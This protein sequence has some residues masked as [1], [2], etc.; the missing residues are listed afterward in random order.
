MS[1]NFCLEN[2]GLKLFHGRK[3]IRD[4]LGSLHM[5]SSLLPVL[6]DLSI[7]GL[8]EGDGGARQGLQL[9]SLEQKYNNLLQSKLTL[10]KASLCFYP[11]EVRT[12][13]DTVSTCKI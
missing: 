13:E 4:P 7:E 6:M 11:L 9:N 1:D 8:A 5:A 2:S 10:Y 3:H 12:Q